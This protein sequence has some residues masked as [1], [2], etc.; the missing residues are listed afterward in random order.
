[1]EFESLYGIRGIRSPTILDGLA[2]Y[3]DKNSDILNLIDA[4]WISGRMVILL[5][6]TGL[7]IAILSCKQA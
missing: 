5:R 6:F 2:K 4:V 7:N 3:G 1:M